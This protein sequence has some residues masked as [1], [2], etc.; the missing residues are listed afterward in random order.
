MS[1]GFEEAQRLTTIWMEMAGKM[2]GEMAGIAAPADEA[3]VKS[4]PDMAK[5]AR[6]V[7]LSALSQYTQSYM[8]SPQFLEMMKQ[9]MDASI[10]WQ[11]QM[12]DWLTRTHHSMESVARCDVEELHKAMRH[13]EQRTLDQMERIVG[14]L[15]EIS[16]RLE[17]LE[18]HEPEPVA[19]G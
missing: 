2:T 10:K 6:D 9:S 13:L 1:S 7:M 17:T 8:R 19:G 12:N 14:K 3:A 11:T 4:P 5:A 16:K 18:S 15:D